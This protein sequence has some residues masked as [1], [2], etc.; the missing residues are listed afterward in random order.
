MKL[1]LRAD[2]E[3]LGR[4][5]DI[6]T[7]KPGFGRNY[8]L[9]QGL[10]MVASDSN[11]RVFEMEKKKLQAKMDAVK[12]AAQELADKILANPVTIEVRVGEGDK[13]YG[14]VTTAHVGDALEALGVVL[15][16]KKIE[17]DEPI[18]ALGE[19]ELEVRLHPDVR[20]A[21]KVTVKK[22]GG[23][24]E[25]PKPVKSEEPAPAELAE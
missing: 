25:Q 4:L 3:N 17:M 18:R 12:A 9:P 24:P 6:V 1:I 7:V 21:L 8:L 16:R 15:D 5:G 23:Q 20:P 22:H 14:S 2:V 19:Y 10:A 13:M 11:L